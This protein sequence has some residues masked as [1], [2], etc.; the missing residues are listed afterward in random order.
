MPSELVMTRVPIPLCPT[1]TNNPLPKVTAVHRLSAAEMRLVQVI[2]S[3]LV[4]TR[5][6]VPDEATATNISLPYAIVNQLLSGE[7]RLVQLIPS[8]LV[9]TRLVPPVPDTA[10]NNPLPYVTANQLLST[11]V[12]LLIQVMPGWAMLNVLVK[13]TMK[14]TQMSFD[15]GKWG[16]VIFNDMLMVSEAGKKFI[17]VNLLLYFI[18]NVF[19]IRNNMRSKE[20]LRVT[21]SYY[22]FIWLRFNYVAL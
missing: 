15:T 8:G 10:T 22:L 11:G 3:G 12:V 2:P 4:I 5:L 6:P 13:R 7:V 21:K 18:A 19:R 1:A 17:E 14:N 16:W 20:S 9:I